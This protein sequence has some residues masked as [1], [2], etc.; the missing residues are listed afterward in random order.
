M[1]ISMPIWAVPV[2]AAFWL[3]VWILALLIWVIVLGGK[4]LL[5]LAAMPFERSRPQRSHSRL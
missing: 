3:A 2:A 5:K 4:G 1:W